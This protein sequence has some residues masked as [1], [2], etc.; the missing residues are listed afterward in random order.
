M[1]LD[2]DEAWQRAN[3]VDAAELLARARASARARPGRPRGPG[4]TGRGVAGR[5]RPRHGRD[6]RLGDA[7]VLRGVRPHAAD[8][9]GLG[10]ARACSATTRPTCGDAFARGAS[11]GHADSPRLRRAAMGWARRPVTASTTSTSTSALRGRSRWCARFVAN[12]S[13][14]V[15][16]VVRRDPAAPLGAID[17]RSRSPAAERARAT[18][19]CCPRSA[20]REPCFRGAPALDRR[21]FGASRDHGPPGSAI[22]GA[23]FGQ[24]R[25]GPETGSFLVDGASSLE[26]TVTA[27]VG[28][29]PRPTRSPG[30][31]AGRREVRG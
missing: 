30:E 15:D 23:R 25:R 10:C 17:V 28:K 24:C 13:F 31:F 20:A 29:A 5:R 19:V 8:R 12:G 9:G 1:P 11:R 14:L 21:R 2:A 3:M 22:W 16:G 26:V 27:I 4:R 18:V 7:P 6:H